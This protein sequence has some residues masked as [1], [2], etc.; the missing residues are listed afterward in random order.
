MHTV[1]YRLS[2]TRP[3]IFLGE[4]RVPVETRLAAS[5]WVDKGKGEI[6][7]ESHMERP[8]VRS[9]VLVLAVLAGAWGAHGHRVRIEAW[10]WHLRH[11]TA[12]NVGNCVV[13][14]PANW[15][16]ESQEDGG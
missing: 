10:L 13:P 1:N 6:Q 9:I 16:V 8:R 14:V 15:Y 2:T 4:K 5:Y 7:S 11:G 3:P 12:I